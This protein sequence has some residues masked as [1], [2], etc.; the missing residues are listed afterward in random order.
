MHSSPCPNKDVCGSCGWSHIPYDKQ[1]EQKLS[2]INGSFALK[3]LNVT[4]EEILASPKLAHYRNRM[5]FVIDFEGRMGLRQKGKWWKVIDGHPC[6]ISDERIETAFHA[7]REWTQRAELSF[8]DRKAHHGF[9]RYAVIRATSTGELM[10]NIVT[11]VPDMPEEVVKEKFDDLHN[12]TQPTTLIWS[13]NDTIS[14]VSFADDV[15]VLHG[16]GY[17]EEVINDHRYRISPNAF[18]QTNSSGAGELLNTVEEFAGDLTNKT[19]L[20]LYCGTGFF[21]IALADKAKKTIGVE[22]NIAAI[23]DAKV[24]AELNSVDVDYHAAPTE[25]FDWSVYAA[26]VVILDPP[27]VGLHDRALADVL[28]IRPKTIIYISCK[29]KNFARELVQLQEHYDI[30]A[31]RA[32]DM[33]PHTPH[34]ELVTRLDRKS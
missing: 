25:D 15:R 21:S 18:F 11:S 8:F 22:M 20:D 13:V 17:I 14:D 28:R 34:V 1:V 3:G 31:M 6:F 16:P 10:I 7:I 9:L 2:D 27:R 26:D 32:I 5:D 33:F 24:N 12:A 30:S 23:E 29:Y 4:C 19:L